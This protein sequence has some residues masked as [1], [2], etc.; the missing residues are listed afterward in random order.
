[1]DGN[2]WMKGCLSG[3][4]TKCCKMLVYRQRENKKKI[5]HTSNFILDCI[6]IKI[7]NFD[8]GSNSIFTD[9]M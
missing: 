5:Q 9:L 8:R 7:D 3:F 4:W 6:E 1:M 2:R